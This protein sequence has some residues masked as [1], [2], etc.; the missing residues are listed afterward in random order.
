MMVEYH[1][2]NPYNNLTMGGL[3]QWYSTATGYCK[4]VGVVRDHLVCDDGLSINS[5]MAFGHYIMDL[6]EITYVMRYSRDNVTNLAR[7]V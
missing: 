4:V 3:L 1:N 7:I 6:V 2:V 5:I